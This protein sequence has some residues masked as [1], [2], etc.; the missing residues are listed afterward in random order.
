MKE[1]ELAVSEILEIMSSSV[2]GKMNGSLS[3][4]KTYLNNS[5][6]KS[7]RELLQENIINAEKST[8]RKRKV[9][10]FCSEKNCRIE[11]TPRQG[12]PVHR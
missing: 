6:N 5:L 3:I 4:P 12:S 7:V 11:K 9:G 10:A 2:D 1:A 8:V